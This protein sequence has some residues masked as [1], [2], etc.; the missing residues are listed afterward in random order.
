MGRNAASHK[1]VKSLN[2]Q[3]GYFYEKL[4]W[5]CAILSIKEW[6][7]SMS[8][9]NKIYEVNVYLKRHCVAHIF[10]NW[11]SLLFISDHSSSTRTE[12]IWN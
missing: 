6:Y 3:V 10:T 5:I 8:T 2:Y 7:D 11:S 12:F 1:K 9:P 4:W